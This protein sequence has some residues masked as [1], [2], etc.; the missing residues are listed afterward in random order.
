MATNTYDWMGQQY[1]RP[2]QNQMNM[3]MGQGRQTGYGSGNGMGLG[4]AG[5]PGWN[6]ASQRDLWGGANGNSKA[7]P[8][9][10]LGGD[11]G[12]STD[13][14]LSGNVGVQGGGRNNQY[15]FSAAMNSNGGVNAAGA[16]NPYSNVSGAAITDPIGNPYQNYQNNLFDPSRWVDNTQAGN[17]Q[18]YLDNTLPFAQFL[19]N[20][21]QYGQDFAES[22]RRW[23]QQ[24]AQ[25]QQ[26][27][28]WN[29]QFAKDQFGLTQWQAQQA[30]QQW[31]QQFAQTQ[32]N[33]AWNQQFAGTSSIV[34][35]VS[36][37]S[38]FNSSRGTMRGISSLPGTSSIARTASGISSLR[39]RR[40]TTLS[41][42]G[43][44]TG[45]R[46]W[47]NRTVMHRSRT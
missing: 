44:Q 16:Q 47:M 21:Q 13:M 12:M 11:Y 37:R 43:W 18:R 41:I 22:Q 20:Q 38:N 34:R 19:Q 5:G 42:R 3:D 17:N 46:R 31:A 27:D 15:A 4:P 40:R 35:T 8:T 45:S 14:G 33:D 36:G 39:R 6:M 10:S 1:G 7:G 25:T 2:D 9:N 26:N 32:G 23:D 30:A 24:M 28:A 29:Q